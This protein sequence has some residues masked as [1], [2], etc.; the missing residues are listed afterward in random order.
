MRNNYVPRVDMQGVS[1]PLWFGT[2]VHYALAQYYSPTLKRDP[3][4]TFS[5]WWE[6]QMHGGLVKE[7][8]LD[9][10]YDRHPKEVEWAEEF[11]EPMYLVKGLMDLHPDP[12]SEIF[13]EHYKLGM[14]M[15][16][17]YKEYAEQ[18]DNFA[19]IVEEHT[20]SVPITDPDGNIIF[21]VDPRD[22]QRKEVHIRGT[23]DAIIQDLEN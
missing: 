17:Y 6:V 7:S 15:L 4:E 3:V 14:G 12:Q 18:H 20:F 13:E 10:S 16:T 23:Q 21:A 19:V 8:E 22:G 2:G 11:I 5:W 9:L 1:M